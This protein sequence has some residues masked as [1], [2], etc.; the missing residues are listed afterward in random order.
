MDSVYVVIFFKNCAHQKWWRIYAVINNCVFCHLREIISIWCSWRNVATI[1]WR[2]KMVY[3][4]KHA[5]YLY[6]ELNFLNVQITAVGHYST[7]VHSWAYSSS[8]SIYCPFLWIL[9]FIYLTYTEY[10]VT[11]YCKECFLAV[12]CLVS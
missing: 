11:C 5:P 3:F 7:T 2:I 10:V 1:C 6:T 4:F 9:Y 12:N 8:N